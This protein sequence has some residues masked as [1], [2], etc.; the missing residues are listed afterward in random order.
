MTLYKLFATGA[1]LFIFE[2]MKAKYVYEST[3]TSKGLNTEKG[4]FE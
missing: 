1:F 2:T 4:P 3:N